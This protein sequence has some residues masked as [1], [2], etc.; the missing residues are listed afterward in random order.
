[1]GD[2]AAFTFFTIGSPL[3]WPAEVEGMSAGDSLT[4]CCGPGGEKGSAAGW[5][6]RV[7]PQFAAPASARDFIDRL[8]PETRQQ[9]IS[10]IKTIVDDLL[11]TGYEGNIHV[12]KLA[13][14]SG[15]RRSAVQ[16]ALFAMQESGH[17][18]LYKMDDGQLAVDRKS[19]G[20]RIN[21]SSIRRGTFAKFAVTI[22]VM[23]LTVGIS[24]ARGLL[25]NGPIH[26]WSMVALLPLMYVGRIADRRLNRLMDAKE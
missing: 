7:P 22:V 26:P 17:Y 19:G 13:R 10:K 8:R 12:D 23:G 3:P 16:D 15:Y 4:V 18:R 20:Q 9:R 21:P 25:M 24:T 2:K 5:D 14:Q 11:D 1:G 6:V